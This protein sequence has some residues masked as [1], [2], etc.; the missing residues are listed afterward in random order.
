[1]SISIYKPNSKNTG[2]GFSLQLGINNKTKEKTLYIKSIKQHSWDSVKKQGYFQE[3]I[4]NPEKNITVKFNEYE[5][6]NLIY[7]ISS[8]NLKIIYFYLFGVLAFFTL[9]ILFLIFRGVNLS[10]LILQIF[11]FPQLIGVDRYSNYVLKQ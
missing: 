2:S 9:F 11:L 7:A 10:D 1:M 5:I 6:G 8:K 3:N 4:G